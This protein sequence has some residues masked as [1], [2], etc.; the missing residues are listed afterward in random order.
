MLF[1]A[2]GR[3]S[4]KERALTLQLPPAMAPRSRVTGYCFT[5]NNPKNEEIEHLKALEYA[6]LILG[7]EKGDKEETP[8][9]QGYIH[10]K[11]NVDFSKVKKL[12]PRAHIEARK[13]SVLQATDYCKKDG[14][15]QEFGIMPVS[16]AEGSKQTWK[17]IMVHAQNGD[18]D[19]IMDNYP[20]VWIQLSNRLEG[21]R[22]REKKI[23]DGELEHEWWVG[24]T[25]TG[26]S[27]ALWELYGEHY[28]KELNKWWCGYQDEVVVAIEEWSP[29]NECTGSQLKIWADRYP[30]TAQ[31]KGGSIKKVRPLKIIVL[32]NF[33]IDACFTDARD[34]EPLRRRFKTF[35]FPE[36]ID[37]VTQ[38]ALLFKQNQATEAEVVNAANNRALTDI[39]CTSSQDMEADH[40]D[41][42]AISDAQV[43]WD[44]RINALLD[45]PIDMHDG[46]E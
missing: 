1:Y 6:Y 7:Y 11:R 17:S 26:K 33:D 21:L 37:E 41:I 4:P 2:V 42:T 30:F 15:F 35:R 18:F 25:G 23:L 34:L 40:I 29:K 8:H 44:D 38:R 16:A 28:Q 31:I 10:F 32:S 20:K 14:V 46:L 13:G 9:I 45:L 39:T 43:D 19:W 22:I 27:K 3:M 12:I 24:T 5:L 36:D